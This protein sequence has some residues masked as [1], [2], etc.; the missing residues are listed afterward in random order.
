VLLVDFVGY[1]K[2]RVER[3]HA[4]ATLK[5]SAR[6]PAELSLHHILRDEIA[7]AL[8]DVEETVDR[9]SRQR[10]FDGCDFGLAQ[11]Q[12]VGLRDRI[13]RRANHRVI[14]GLIDELAE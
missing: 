10:R 3:V 13:D 7:S 4:H 6:I 5:A 1:R 2:E 14:D 8:S 11:R 12:I 9:L